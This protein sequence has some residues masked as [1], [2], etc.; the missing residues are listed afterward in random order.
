MLFY[1]ASAPTGWTKITTQNDKALRVVSGTGGGSGGSSSFTSVFASRSVPLARH[2]HS[3]TTIGAG[4]HSHSGSTS[5]AGSHSHSGST[6]GA[7]AHSHSTNFSSVVTQPGGNETPGGGGRG[8]YQNISINGVG[9]HAHSFSTSG[10]GDHA[11]SFS[12]SGVGDHAHTFSTSEEGT[13][14]ASM[15]FSVQYI[16]VIICQ[17]N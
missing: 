12:T 10:V 6:S 1:E 15:N 11:H 2:S 17:K 9:D 14:G 7:G 16:D 5:G 3:G 13:S 4:S 8:I